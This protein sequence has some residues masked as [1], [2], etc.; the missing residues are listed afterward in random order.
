MAFAEFSLIQCLVK[1][2]RPCKIG[3]KHRLCLCRDLFVKGNERCFKIQTT[4]PIVEIGR[5]NRRYL[6]IHKNDLLMHEP[7]VVAPC[8]NCVLGSYGHCER[9][10]GDL[11]RF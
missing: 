8:Q 3:F 5:A 10:F 2:E 1:F 4:G 9:L 11:C 7:F 6:V